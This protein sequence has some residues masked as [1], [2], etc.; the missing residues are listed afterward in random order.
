MAVSCRGDVDKPSAFAS[1]GRKVGRTR[2]V[3]VVAIAAVLLACITLFLLGAAQGAGIVVQAWTD[4]SQHG[5]FSSTDLTAEFLAVI[6]S[7]LRAVVMDLLGVG[8]TACPSS[9]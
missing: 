9:R 6:G 3:V 7:M 2:H 8:L 1:L 5:R 4:A